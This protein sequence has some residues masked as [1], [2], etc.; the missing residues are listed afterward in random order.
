ME[1]W[2]RISR[3]RW[4]RVTIGVLA[5]EYIRLVG[6]TNSVIT[7]P[8]DGYDRVERD[9]PVIV[10][11]WHGQHMLA[12]NVRKPHHKA[13]MLVSRH[14]DGD[15]N[16][17]A[18]KRLGVDIIRGSGNHGQSFVH[19]NGVAAFQS[20]VDALAEGYS[21]ALSA[22]VPKVSRV[23]GV[24]IIKLAQI[25]GRPIYPVAIATSRRLVLDN[26][27]RT[28]INLPFGRGAGVGPDPIR[29]APDANADAIESARLLLEQ[30]LNIATRRAYELV[31]G[32]KAKQP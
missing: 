6:K 9:L 23:A 1:V 18:A 17:I 27:D 30:R 4:A 32:P 3:Q 11:F 25:S 28:T 5:A 31:D 8:A 12:T 26:W 2:R 7:E 14:F 13:K 22:D 24:G 10:T 19:K 21:V 20:M 16:A 29:V 15:I